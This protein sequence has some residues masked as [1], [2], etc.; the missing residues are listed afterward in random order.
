MPLVFRTHEGT[1]EFQRRADLHEQ[2]L[3]IAEYGIGIEALDSVAADDL[4]RITGTVGPRQFPL[5][6]VPQKQMPVVIVELIEIGALAGTL[7]R[8][9]ESNF[10]EASYLF[11]QVGHFGGAG[12]VHG[13]VIRLGE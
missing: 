8:V 12:C 1:A 3:V 10:P 5:F 6:L 7:A 11:Q 4:V 9:A 2:A 13:K